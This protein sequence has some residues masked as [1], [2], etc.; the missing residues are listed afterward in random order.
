MRSSTRIRIANQSEQAQ[1][2]IKDAKGNIFDASRHV[3]ADNR[4]RSGTFRL[5]R[6]KR[7]A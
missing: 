4:T 7:H 5:L 1:A 2:P 6:G 3:A